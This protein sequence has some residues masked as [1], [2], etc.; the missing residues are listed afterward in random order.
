MKA[1]RKLLRVLNVH[2]DEWWLVRKLFMMQFFQGA[3]ITFFFTAAFS[4]FLEL[5][6][7]SGLAY[8]FI[9]SSFLLWAT[10]FIYSKLEHLLSPYRLSMVVTAV[11]AGSMILFWI[12]EGFISANWFY[13]V[14]LAWFNV[15]Y[16]LNNLM[17]WGMASQLYDVRQSKRLFSVISAG[18]I[19]AKF[20]GYSLALVAVSYIGTANLLIPGLV[21]ILLSFQY[22][23]K[24]L[25]PSLEEKKHHHTPSPTHITNL[26]SIVKNFWVNT[27]VRRVALLS[28]IV[29][30]CI[31]LINYGFYSEV[32]QQNKDD[33]ALATFITLFLASARLIALLIKVVITSRLL[34][35]LGNR[36]ALS[37]TPVLLILLIASLQV[38]GALSSSTKLVLY[39]FG[40]AAIVTEVLNSAINAP[41][42]LTMMQP[43]STLERLRAHNI[44]KGI[45][46]PFAYLLSG[47][48]ILVIVKMKIFDLKILSYVLFGLTIAWIIGIFK[49]HREY[50]KALIKTI[51]SRYFTQDEFNLFDPA[52]KEIIEK[53]LKNGVELE[54][55]YILRML[56]SR[57][58]E[59]SN[60]LIML[61]LEHPSSK[62]V[63]EALHIIGELHIREAEPKLLSLVEKSESHTIRSTAVKMSSKIA[64]DDTAISALMENDEAV[65]RHSAIISVLNHSRSEAHRQEAERRI[66]EMLNSNLAEERL[67]AVTMLCETSHG[68]FDN[69]LISLLDEKNAEILQKVIRAIGH[70]PSQACLERILHKTDIDKHIIEALVISGETAI[71]YI[72]KRLFEKD[73]T[74]RHKEMLINVIGR[75]NGKEGISMLIQLLTVMPEFHTLII[76]VLHRHRYKADKE[77]Q[78]VIESLIHTYL[79]SAAVMLNM[80]RKIQPGNQQYN[81]LFGSL[82]LELINTRETLLYLFSF[83]FDRDKINKIK[84]AIEINKKETNANAIELVDMTVKKEFANPF[85]AAFE[86]GDLEHRCELLKYLFPKNTYHGIDS[87]LS[88]LLVDKKFSYNNWTK[89]SALY[90]TKKFGPP[91]G[92]QLI[93]KYLDAENSLV[94]ETAAFAANNP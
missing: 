28:L 23:K 29:S 34:Y 55:M 37:I 79:S 31:I 9:L 30:A 81:I 44:V 82:Q 69:E 59:E 11:L 2:R 32:K 54:V 38:T 13:F 27:L 33:V 5:F 22:I 78:P 74:A 57:R 88:E 48:F 12:G 87:I 67:Q 8:V 41:I 86:H 15:M 68:A 43:L 61:A 85:N 72:K 71:P 45:M 84:I 56:S 49:V 65:V 1:S 53:K 60:R 26:N 66:R 4:R 73:C 93:N 47:L 92:D 16:L 91:I 76:K 46:D 6:A 25:P 64:Y 75:I 83:L 24:I 17:F 70:H 40:L 3:G 52:T 62:I 90:T 14:M 42:L 39:I 94:K 63:Q 19:P 58:S 35:W 89:A 10:G 21:F 77:S 80:Q 50:L 20:I 7:V 51:S 36:S 18:D